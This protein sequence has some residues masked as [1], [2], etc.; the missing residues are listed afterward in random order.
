[1]AEEN[2]TALALNL[3]DLSSYFDKEALVDLENEIY[4]VG[5]RG[6]LYKLIHKVNKDRRISVR[7]AVEESEK[8]RTLKLCRDIAYTLYQ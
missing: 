5:I 2:G 4:K 8:T 1:M 7:T 3:M 6:K